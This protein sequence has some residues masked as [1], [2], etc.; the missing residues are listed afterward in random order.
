MKPL[1]RVSEASGRVRDTTPDLYGQRDRTDLEAAMDGCQVARRP[2]GRVDEVPPTTKPKSPPASE[3]MEAAGIEPAERLPPPFRRPSGADFEWGGVVRRT[4]AVVGLSPA[5][6]PFRH[7]R[8]TTFQP[9]VPGPAGI[10]GPY[11]P[12]CL[13]AVKP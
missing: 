8:L 1:N 10:V 6:A 7:I 4:P 12:L 2:S 13:L 9:L 5:S 11:R 3:R